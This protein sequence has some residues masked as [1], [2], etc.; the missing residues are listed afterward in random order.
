MKMENRLLTTVDKQGQ[1][2]GHKLERATLIFCPNDGKLLSRN[3]TT[4]YF[5]CKICGYKVA[6]QDTERH[7]ETVLNEEQTLQLIKDQLKEK[8]SF[9]P[10][11]LSECK[12]NQ[13]N[14]PI[15]NNI[16]KSHPELCTVRFNEGKKH[17]EIII[18]KDIKR[19]RINNWVTDKINKLNTVKRDKYNIFRLV[20]P[21]KGEDNSFYHSK[22]G[23][24]SWVGAF[25]FYERIKDE[26]EKEL[27]FDVFIYLRGKQGAG[28]VN[29]YGIM[30][31]TDEVQDYVIDFIE[32]FPI[33]DGTNID[34]FR[35]I[36]FTPP[37][38]SFIDLRI[39]EKI[40]EVKKE[41]EREVKK[42]DTEI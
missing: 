7:L 4:M 37:D 29:S 26:L 6:D 1:V 39:S 16:A 17:F 27:D 32:S 40:E 19:Q 10:Y 31:I 3:Q 41:G 8:D 18:S 14:I 42:L 34:H 5:E 33:P 9:F 35:L 15:I 25:P 22:R 12:K 13:R 36:P 38:G 20:N 28:G 2:I 30:L 11:A 21:Y 24:N 23:R